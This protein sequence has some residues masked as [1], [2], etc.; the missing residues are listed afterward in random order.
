MLRYVRRFVAALSAPDEDGYYGRYK[1]ANALLKR[2]RANDVLLLAR[3]GAVPLA[4]KF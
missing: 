1:W 3:R 4:G 2:R